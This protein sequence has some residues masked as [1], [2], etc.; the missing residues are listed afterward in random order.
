MST[1][2]RKK[3]KLMNYEKTIQLYRL[4]HQLDHKIRSSNKQIQNFHRRVEEM[5]HCQ[6]KKKYQVTKLTVQ[7]KERRKPEQKI[8]LVTQTEMDVQWSKSTS[9][10]KRVQWEWCFLLEDPLSPLFF[11]TVD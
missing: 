4:H 9:P 2:E 6:K 5:V 3:R 1:S 11:P 7:Q 8:S 10:S